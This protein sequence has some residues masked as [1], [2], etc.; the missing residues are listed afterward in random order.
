MRVR[1][2]QRP[3]SSRAIRTCTVLSAR[4][5]R[6]LTR[7][8]QT[9]RSSPPGGDQ[10]RIEVVQLPAQPLLSA[11][12]FVD[13]VV[14]VIGKQL[15]LARRRPLRRGSLRRGSRSA[16][17]ATASASIGSDL[18][19]TDLCAGAAPSASVAPA[20]TTRLQQAAPARAPRST[21]GNPLPPKAGHREATQTKQPARAARRPSPPRPGAR[22]RQ[23]QQPSTTACVRPHQQRSFDSPPTEKGATDERTD[24]TRGSSHAPIRSRS[25]VSGRRRRHNAGKSPLGRHAGMESAAA[26]PSLFKATDTTTTPRMTVSSE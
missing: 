8:S 17:L 11:P 21:A 20:P 22:P 10:L 13:K 5:S 16:A 12:P 3:T 1:L 2:R 6:R 19:R 24:L 7:S 14:S 25:T 26:D 15:Q 4:L 23:P 9:V 18:P